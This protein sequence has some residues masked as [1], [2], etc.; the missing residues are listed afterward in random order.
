MKR[1]G[2]LLLILSLS[3]PIVCMHG[4]QK[5]FN[6]NVF[7]DGLQQAIHQQIII[8]QTF[9]KQVMKDIVRRG[10][11]TGTYKKRKRS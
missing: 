3:G 10:F 4:E 9:H 6:T 1:I 8:Q 5:E 7:A 2:L 11:A